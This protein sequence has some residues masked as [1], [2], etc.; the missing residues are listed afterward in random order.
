MR[1]LMQYLNGAALAS[2]WVFF[3]HIDKLNYINLQTFNK[4][5][6]MVQQQFIIAELSQDSSVITAHITGIPLANL[7]IVGNHS[8]SQAQ[9]SIE[10][11]FNPQRAALNLDEREDKQDIK[12]ED[13]FNDE[14]NLENEEA[15][16]DE[17]EDLLPPHPKHYENRDFDELELENE[18]PLEGE[19]EDNMFDSDNLD[20]FKQDHHKEM[21]HK[22]L[23]E[24]KQ[25]ERKK[26]KQAS[27]K[28]YENYEQEIEENFKAQEKISAHQESSHRRKEADKT[29][30]HDTTHDTASKMNKIC[31]GVF[32]SISHEFILDNTH[33]ADEISLSLQ[34]AFRV[35]SLTRP[36]YKIILK[37][38]L[39]CEGIR[40]YDELGE[41]V[42]EFVNRIR[43]AAPQGATDKHFS[44]TYYDVQAIVKSIGFLTEENWREKSIRYAK[45]RAEKLEQVEDPTADYRDKAIL[46]EKKIESESMIDSMERKER[47]TVEYNAAMKSLEL[48]AIQR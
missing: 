43:A 19:S 5:I 16:E 31:F 48:Y 18:R 32:A 1:H 22:M 21:L 28:D 3:E 4:E 41:N 8:H 27:K 25:Y 34:S 37:T 17:E 36:E 30:S 40:S 20:A 39:K 45:I 29:A 12:I 42:L 23:T 26:S 6:Q 13:N 9:K 46:E 10:Q 14:A 38:L 2:I 33:K 7:Y 15:S 47:I 24:E 11:R 44:F 35:I